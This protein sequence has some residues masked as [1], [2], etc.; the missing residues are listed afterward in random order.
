MNYLITGAAGYVGGKL[1]EMLRS[2]GEAVFAATRGDFDYSHIEPIRKYFSGKHIDRVIHLAG[3]VGSRS[4]EEFYIANISG[5]YALLQVCAENK[6]AHITYSSSNNVYP[7]NLKYP[8]K[9]NELVQPS[10]DNLYGISKYAG[11]LI[12]SDFCKRRNMSFANV[13]I[14]DIYG[15]DQK[16]GNLLKAIVSAV[17]SRTPLKLYGQGLRTRDY[18]Y[19]TDVINGLAFIGGRN[20]CGTFNLGSGKGTSVRQLVEIANELSGGL[21]AIE[22]VPCIA[23]DTSCVFLDV[24][25]LEDAGY[26]ASVDIRDGLKMTIGV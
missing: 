11:E 9:E 7:T 22:N 16:Y 8:H 17:R 6:V 19:I 18:I 3:A 26:K 21:C 2:R 5:L 4:P 14:A 15:P 25:K 12:V 10:S 20:L 24:G 23:E 1:T 13:R